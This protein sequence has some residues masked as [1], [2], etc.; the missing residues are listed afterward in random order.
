MDEREK[1]KI[2]VSKRANSIGEV[3]E[4][5]EVLID[6]HFFDQFTETKSSMFLKKVLANQRMIGVGLFNKTWRTLNCYQKT[7]K[8]IRE[9]QENLLCIGESRELVTKK[10]SDTKCW[11]NKTGQTLNAKHI[12]S[13]CKKVSAEIN[14]RHDTMVNTS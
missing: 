5:V 4:D 8:V 6:A 3:L 1:N 9:I 10:K 12:R 14:F 11:C 7:M 2:L 13:C